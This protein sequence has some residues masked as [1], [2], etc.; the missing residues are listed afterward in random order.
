MMK[1]K[2][3]LWSGVNVY[4]RVGINYASI[5]NTS[6]GGYIGGL[7]GFIKANYDD[8]Q[9][10]ELVK[11][12]LSVSSLFSEEF[13]S[14]YPDYLISELALDLAIDKEGNIQLIEIHINKP[15]IIYYEFDVARHAIPYCIS[16]A[17]QTES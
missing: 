7:E 15:G 5:S 11:K 17:K 6:L 10:K 8:F 2:Q 9:S 16:L 13:E 4:P 3:Q 1:D 14:L 12:V